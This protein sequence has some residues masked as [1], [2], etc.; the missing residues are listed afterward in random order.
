MR[1]RQRSCAYDGSSL[2]PQELRAQRDPV[3]LQLALSCRALPAFITASSRFYDICL[4]Q[5]WNHWC[6]F[7]RNPR[8]PAKRAPIASNS[9]RR[10]LHLRSL[11]VKA[12]H[13]ARRST[14]FSP[15]WAEASCHNLSGLATGTPCAR[16]TDNHRAAGAGTKTRRHDKHRTE[17]FTALRRKH[18]L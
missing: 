4:G 1:T 8:R 10:V 2:M 18:P 9:A 7:T 13:P 5:K 16:T 12:T 17:R 3:W 6:T 15:D 11:A 14:H